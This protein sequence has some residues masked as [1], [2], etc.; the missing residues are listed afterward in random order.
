MDSEFFRWSDY[1]D[2]ELAVQKLCL[3]RNPELFLLLLNDFIVDSI[4]LMYKSII[5]VWLDNRFLCEVILFYTFII[6]CCIAVIWGQI[7]AI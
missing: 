2:L 6:W 5:V 3:V 1:Q 4:F 7:L